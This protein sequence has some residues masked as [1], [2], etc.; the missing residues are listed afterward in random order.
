MLL[1]GAPFG[2]QL[3]AAVNRLWHP[4]GK[5]FESS[6]PTPFGSDIL[7]TGA[8]QAKDFVGWKLSAHGVGTK[9]D[10]LF[11]QLNGITT[12]HLIAQIFNQL[13]EHICVFGY[14]DVIGLS[15]RFGSFLVI[16]KNHHAAGIS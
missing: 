2:G 5:F 4:I 16:P 10:L 15:E 6:R 9:V 8:Y 7:T 13:I 3:V 12:C 14:G 11:T 1:H